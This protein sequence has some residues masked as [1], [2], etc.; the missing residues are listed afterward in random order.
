M[1]RLLVLIVVLTLL[2]ITGT[3]VSADE[4]TGVT[5]NEFQISTT[6]SNGG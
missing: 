6:V 3:F 4:Q 1:K 2:V 5:N